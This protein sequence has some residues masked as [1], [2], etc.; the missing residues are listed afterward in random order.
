[1]GIL[2]KILG[3]NKAPADEPTSQP[4]PPGDVAG[5]KEPKAAQE[6]G[7]EQSDGAAQTPGTPPS[8]ET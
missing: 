5:E 1:M 7:G 3:R 6:R 4:S 2:D 8:A